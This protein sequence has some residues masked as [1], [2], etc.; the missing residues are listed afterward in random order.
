MCAC[1]HVCAC[2]GNLKTKKFL[3]AAGDGSCNQAWNQAWIQ[4]C[5]QTWT[6][7]HQVTQPQS[8]H[9]KRLSPSRHTWMLCTPSCSS[10]CASAPLQTRPNVTSPK[11]PGP[12][13]SSHTCGAQP[14]QFPKRGPLSLRYALIAHKFAPISFHVCMPFPHMPYARPSPQPSACA[15][16][17]PKLH[18]GAHYQS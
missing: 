15:P 4:T 11:Y 5:N 8:G 2:A 9:C 18:L 17:P 10:E 7:V 6:D 12:L 13:I 3:R 16:T 1:V 14:S